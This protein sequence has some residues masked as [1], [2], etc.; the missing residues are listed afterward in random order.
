M[1]TDVLN[2]AL[3]AQNIEVDPVQQ[4]QEAGFK[5]V[6][7]FTVVRAT[8]VLHLLPDC[9]LIPSYRKNAAI[10]LLL[11]AQNDETQS[12]VGIRSEVSGGDYFG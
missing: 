5:P 1:V 4:G 2:D 3:P 10:D 9:V 11:W 12:H 8:T 7:L 6:R